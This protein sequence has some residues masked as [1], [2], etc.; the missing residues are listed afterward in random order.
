ME[1]PFRS[2]A[3]TAHAHATEDEQRVLSA[4]KILLP[5]AEIRLTKL[6]GHYGNPIVGFEAAVERRKDVRELWQRVA[7]KLRTGELETLRNIARERIDETCHLYMRFDKQLAY[8]GELVLT[9]S[10]DAMHLRL[11]VAAFPAKREVAIGL[12]EKF[13]KGGSGDDAEAE[14]HSV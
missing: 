4:L 2:A 12:V 14:I 6:T 5:S 11:K 1:F 9:D 13:I 3:V 10:G 8:G 7:A